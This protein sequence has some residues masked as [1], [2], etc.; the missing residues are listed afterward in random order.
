MN[1][2]LEIGVPIR[3]DPEASFSQK[4]TAVLGAITKP[5]ILI[6]DNFESLL[7]ANDKYKSEDIGDL[8]SSLVNFEHKAKALVT[9]R[10]LPHGI[11]KNA[12]IRVLSL[13]GLDENSAKELYQKRGGIPYSKFDAKLTDVFAKLEG[14]P[15]FIE[16]FATAISELPKD[17]IVAGLLSCHRYW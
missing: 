9:T 10:R 17:Q 4:I 6:L 2:G 8:M 1:A 5:C 12:G 13:D 3:E 11:L 15:K 7:D 14:H 16:M